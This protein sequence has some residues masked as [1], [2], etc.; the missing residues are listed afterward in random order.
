MAFLNWEHETV[1]LPIGE[2][3][4][5]FRT[6]SFYDVAFLAPHLH[7]IVD[8]IAEGRNVKMVEHAAE[9]VKHI[10]P[11]LVK[12]KDFAQFT[13]DHTD[14]LMAFYKSQDWAR[15]KKMMELDSGEAAEPSEENPHERNMDNF[16]RLCFVAVGKNVNE[17]PKFANKRFEFVADVF[18]EMHARWKEQDEAAHPGRSTVEGFKMLS[19]A[20]A[21]HVVKSEN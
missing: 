7:G 4:Y 19:M 16:R 11:E 1:T 13:S 6:L 3:H 21:R 17:A 10:C 2:G 12:S 20:G 15:I 18:I 5:T 8:A 9:I 14:T